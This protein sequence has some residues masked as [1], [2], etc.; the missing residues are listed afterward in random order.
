[1][2]ARIGARLTEPRA[3][4]PMLDLFLLGALGYAA[5]DRFR[6]HTGELLT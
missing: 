5:C 1:M 3:N 4:C 2:P 6:R